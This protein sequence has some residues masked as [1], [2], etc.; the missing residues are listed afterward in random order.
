MH[1]PTTRATPPHHG[2]TRM[3][4]TFFP[5]TSEGRP[6]LRCSCD[7]EGPA[8]LLMTCPRCKSEINLCNA[9]AVDVLQWLALPVA[10]YGQVPARELAARCRRRLW[11]EPRNHD[12]ALSGAE[13][14]SAIGLDDDDRVVVSG[15]R[16]GYLRDQTGRLLAVAEVAGDGLVC[17]A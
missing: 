4:I 7:I 3:S 8:D 12:G 15:R 10:D 13:R 17:W 11:D 5:A 16:E 2:D 14:A 6:L 1:V 9:N